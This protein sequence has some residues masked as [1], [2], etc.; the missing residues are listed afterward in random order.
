MDFSRPSG[1]E[2]NKI[3]LFIAIV[4]LIVILFGVGYVMKISKNFNK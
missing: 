1:L 4:L 3:V 2:F